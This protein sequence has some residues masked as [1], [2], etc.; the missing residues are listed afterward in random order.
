MDLL[1][2]EQNYATLEEYDEPEYTRP[3]DRPEAFIVPAIFAFIY[4]V[5][6]LGNGTLVIMFLH[7]RSMK[8]I[9]NT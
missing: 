6:I 9:P 3:S 1:D 2:D 4:I 5:G 7:H 8:N